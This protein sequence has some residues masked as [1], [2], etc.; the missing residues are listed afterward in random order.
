[1]AD[2]GRHA[3]RRTRGWSIALISFASLASLGTLFAGLLTVLVARVVV[4]PP[5]S[6]KEETTIESVDL[7]AGT[8][9]LGS[10][11]DARVP[12]RYGL[13]FSLN[14]GHAKLGEIVDQ[15][16][17][18]VTR[19]LL[20]VDFGDI[21][22][23][24]RGRFSGWFHLTPRELGYPYESVTLDTTLGGA[25]AWLIPASSPS[26]RWVVNV[27]GRGVTRSE[28]LRSVPVFHE[29]GFNSL[30]VSWRN[31]GDAPP[32][33]DK[34]YALGGA[35]WLDV[36]AGIRFAIDHGATDVVLMGWSMGGAIVLQA[37]NRSSFADV[38]RGIVLE[39]PVVDWA[40][41][42][43]FQAQ[44]M[45][46]P[47]PVRLAVLALLGSGRAHR[48][49]GKNEPI[50]FAVL[51]FVSRAR[52]LSLP[53]LLLHSE[54]DGYV[55]PTASHALALA[56]PDI[57]TFHNWEIARHARLWNYDSERFD[58]EIAEWLA[59]LPL[60]VQA[61]SSARTGHPHRPPAPD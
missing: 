50:D 53:I 54:D 22:L 36:E 5:K 26:T 38:L 15:T 61:G 30:L 44:A 57:V 29:A 27:H 45:R 10:S 12:G 46:L 42:L 23:A 20:G 55:P 59:T 24:K 4:T 41:T 47:R 1:M 18:T 56:R 8:V 39:S 34:R 9:T 35:E 14:D 21:T 3:A 19:R 32:S 25:P 16:P 28:N 51:D 49:T 6:R 13:W 37:A 52:E 7:V 11:E 2:S 17:Q 58:R 31:D 40:P 33:L 60:G 48:L 43:D